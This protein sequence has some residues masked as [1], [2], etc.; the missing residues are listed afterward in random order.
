MLIFYFK[1]S[2][3]LWGHPQSTHDPG[4]EMA[5]KKVRQPVTGAE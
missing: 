5:S 2:Q 1:F 4:W 3:L